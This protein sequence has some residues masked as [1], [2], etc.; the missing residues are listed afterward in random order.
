MSKWID[1]RARLPE[2]QWNINHPFL[3]E[4]VLIANNCAIVIG[5]Y[6]RRDGTWYID[7]P[8]KKEWIDKIRYW[9]PLPANPCD[10]KVNILKRWRNYLYALFL[11]LAYSW[12]EYFIN[13]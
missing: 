10:E 4:E 3:S 5:F 11:P 1:V 13:E 2:G 6:D 9:M 12:N 8:W 7:E